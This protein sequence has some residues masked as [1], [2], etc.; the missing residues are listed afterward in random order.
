MGEV[1][2]RKIQAAIEATRGLDLA[3]TRKVYAK[4][5]MTKDVVLLRPEEDRGTFIKNYRSAQGIVTAAFPITGG[6][7]YEDLP[8]YAEL[9][10]KGSVTSTVVDTT[11]R[12]WAFVPTA[13]VDDLQTATFEW[14][15]DTQAF[16]MN[17]GMVDTLEISGE[18]ATGGFWAFS[19]GI[20]GTDMAKTTFTGALGERVVEDI[21][22]F[23]TKCAIGAAGAVPSS[24]MTG[25][26]IGFKFNLNN[27]LMRKFFAD[28][29]V[30]TLGGIGRN[31]REITLEVT[32]EGNAATVTERDAYEAG[33][34]RVV[35][36]TALGTTIAGS[37]PTHAR[38]ADLIV[39]GKWRSFEIGERDTNTIFTGVLE[40]EYDATLTYDMSLTVDNL[41]TSFPP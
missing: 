3:A 17:Y 22:M 25:R 27:G 15:D 33:T 6:L 23:L 28:G 11:V 29:T 21:N 14:G 41:V 31:K 12:R 8:W 9:A 39:C 5:M 16:Q 20:I 38:T 26:F 30:P 32:M 13:S 4:G 7:T 40:A 19:A 18:A 10:I 2:L 37:S 24:Y 36:I 35:R 34:S 1:A